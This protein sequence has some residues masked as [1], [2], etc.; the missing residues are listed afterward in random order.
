LPFKERDG[1]QLGCGSPIGKTSGD[2]FPVFPVFPPQKNTKNTTTE[3]YEKLTYRYN[4]D[5]VDIN[6]RY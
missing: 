4:R 6:T 1:A 5:A 3:L 2:L